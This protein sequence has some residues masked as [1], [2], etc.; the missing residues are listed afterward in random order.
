MTT[1][2]TSVVFE[3]DKFLTLNYKNLLKDAVSIFKHHEHV[4]DYF[5]D[6][7]T[8]TR[9]RIERSG[10][11]GTDFYKYVWASLN[12]KALTVKRIEKQKRV[13][14]HHSIPLVAEDENDYIKHIVLELEAALQ[15]DQEINDDNVQ[16][17]EDLQYHTKMVFQFVDS[18]YSPAQA[19]VFKEYFLEPKCTYKK[20]AKRTGLSITY[21]Q[22]A[23][24]PIRKDLK[25]NYVK[26]LKRTQKAK[27]KRNKLKKNKPKV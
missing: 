16:Y 23:I 3:F 17:H 10:F 8:Y 19:S 2:F 14:F 24:T 1:G 6:V 12:G 9:Q 18:R 11:T 27:P 5:H 26:W 22:Q 15:L 20:I 21:C 7:L 13:D 4:Q 25:Q